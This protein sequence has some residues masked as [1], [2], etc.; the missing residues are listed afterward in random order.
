MRRGLLLLFATAL[1]SRALGLCGDSLEQAFRE[2]R[3]VALVQVETNDPR[4]WAKDTATLLVITSWKGP[5]HAGATLHAVPPTCGSYP[6]SVYPF[7]VG[8]IVLVFAPGYGELISPEPCE[9]IGQH[10]AEVVMPQL[11]KL[12]WAAGT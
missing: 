10:D 5:Y 12:S 7:Q 2:A 8:E 4:Q 6:C 11:Y 9:V 1:S 3:I